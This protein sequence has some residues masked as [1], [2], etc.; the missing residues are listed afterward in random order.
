MET[1]EELAGLGADQT[2]QRLES[3]QTGLTATEAAQRLLRFGS[4]TIT[5]HRLTPLAIL[6]GQFKNPILILLAVA[7]VISGALGETGNAVTIAVILT[8]SV[9]LSFSTEYRAEKAS[10]DLQKQTGQPVVIL[11]DAGLDPAN[12]Q[13]FAITN[14]GVIFFFS[15]GTLLPEAAGAMQVLVPRSVVDPLLA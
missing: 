7:A 13:N 5:T 9:L 3:A 12:Y 1:L 14:E 4:N 6:L 8:M 15:Q 2:L 11:P 10:A